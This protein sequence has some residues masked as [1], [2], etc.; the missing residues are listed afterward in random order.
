MKR[1]KIEIL[2][3]NTTSFSKISVPPV[4]N[5]FS[6]TR[7]QLMNSDRLIFEGTVNHQTQIHKFKSN[8]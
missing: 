4:K 1:N 8:I 2:I 6:S 5:Y 3:G 7:C